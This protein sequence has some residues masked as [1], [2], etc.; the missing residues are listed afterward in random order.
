VKN[1]H[2]LHGQFIYLWGAPQIFYHRA[3]YVI[4]AM[5]SGSLGVTSMAAACVVWP[6]VGLLMMGASAY[7]LGAALACRWVGVFAVTALFLLPDA[8]TYGL[9]NG[10]F[11]FHWLVAIAPGSGYGIALLLTALSCFVT[12]E[13][14]QRWSLKLAG[15]FLAGLAALFKAQIAIPGT[16]LLAGLLFASW[17]PERRWHRWAAAGSIAGLAAGAFWAC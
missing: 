3:S 10:F 8:S 4:A 9:Q 15:L 5:V 11:S 14:E 12:G 16:M 1:H 2:A 17:Q 7:G 13:R 6:S